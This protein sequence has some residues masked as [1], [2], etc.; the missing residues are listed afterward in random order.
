MEE[1]YYQ[2]LSIFNTERGEDDLPESNVFL[3][4]LNEIRVIQ[5]DEWKSAPVKKPHSTKYILHVKTLERLFVRAGS[6]YLLLK[7]TEESPSDIGLVYFDTADLRFFRDHIHGKLERCKVRNRIWLG[8]NKQMLEIWK[9]SNKGKMKKFKL[10]MSIDNGEMPDDTGDHFQLYTGKTAKQL[11]ATVY[12]GF[13]RIVLVS[14]DFTEKITIDRN[15]SFIP[16]FKLGKPLYLKGLAMVEIRKPESGL[17]SFESELKVSG[18]IKLNV[19]KYCL[20]VVMTHPEIKTNSYKPV[21]L[22][23]AKIIGNDHT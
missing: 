6:E 5:Y 17:T 16:A 23:I 9:R 3:G 21:L 7:Q 20:G 13:K 18:A 11:L 2:D 1:F 22:N 8:Q 14:P 19:S 4:L 10:P 12:I 15:I